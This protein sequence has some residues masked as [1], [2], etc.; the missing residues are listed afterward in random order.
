MSEIALPECVVVT[1]SRNKF[2]SFIHISP[3]LRPPVGAGDVLCVG[4]GEGDPL[5]VLSVG[6]GEVVVELG[7]RGVGLVHQVLVP[8]S[9]VP[10]GHSQSPQSAQRLKPLSRQ[11][12]LQQ[13]VVHHPPAL[14]GGILQ[15]VTPGARPLG[16]GGDHGSR[17]PHQVDDL[18]LG[19]SHPGLQS[20]PP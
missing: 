3:Q 6:D 17:V 12:I 15:G 9:D 4:P 19:L 14:E 16:Y 20:G 13:A 18:D 2:L 1:T 11:N 8:H 5:N 10:A 7:Q